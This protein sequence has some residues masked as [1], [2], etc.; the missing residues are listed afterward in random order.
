MR[1]DPDGG[2]PPVVDRLAQYSSDE[3]AQIID[4]EVD[5]FGMPEPPMTWL[6]KSEHFGVWVGGRLVGH[7][8]IVVVRADVDGRD[9]DA[10]GYGGVIV[11]RD[12]RGR[13]LVRLVITAATERARQLGPNVGLLFCWDSR[14]PI[15]HRYGWQ[16]LDVEVTVSQPCGPRVMPLRTMWTALHPGATWPT[17]P[18]RLLSLPM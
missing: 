9:I 15:Y 16:L 7:A 12:F 14:V 2:D 5:P 17:G 1:M 13:G 10:V 8:G 18:V 11:H 3:I 6:A 4:G